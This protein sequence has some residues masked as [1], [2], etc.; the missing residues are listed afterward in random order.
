M[1]IAFLL[2]TLLIST[3]S[4]AG[5]PN[6]D[7]WT[8]LLKKHVDGSG[9]VNYKNFKKDVALLDAYIKDLKDNPTE[10]DWSSNEKKAYWINAYNAY[11]IKLV[12]SKYPIKSINDLKFDGKSAFDYKFIDLGSSKM[13]LNDLETNKLRTTFKD[14]R[15]HVAINCA[16]VS[17]PLLV[18]KAFT[19]DNIE[20]LLTAQTKKFLSDKS[21]NKVTANKLELSNIFKWYEDDFNGVIAFINKYSDCEV[22]S[23]ATITYLDYNWNLNAQ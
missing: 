12:I 2:I 17:C 6:H 20:S 21:R 14:A 11:A 8:T 3:I 1:K 7:N 18:N 10:S 15:V 23:K 19:A 16:S 13:S 4:L 22:D 9:K 5:K